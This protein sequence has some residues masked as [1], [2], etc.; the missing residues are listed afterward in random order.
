MSQTMLLTKR[1]STFLANNASPQLHTLLLL[2]P[3]GKILSSSS[4]S[5]ASVLRTQATLACS[6]WNIY[7]P[8]PSTTS[9]IISSSLPNSTPSPDSDKDLNSITIQLSHGIMVIRVLQSGLL[10]VAIGPSTTG[11][12][13]SPVPNS[14]TLHSHHHIASPHTSPSSSPAAHIDGHGSQ[15]S[16]HVD[17]LGVWSFASA[18]S[19][20]PSEAGSVGTGASLGTPASILGVRRQAEEVGRWLEG[21]LEGFVLSAGDGR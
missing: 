9:S 5:S 20:A 3:T 10:F 17:G 6:L 8:F 16:L 18:G 11:V 14:Q 4:P 19:A 7:H 2:S 15:A 13:P 12:G 21:K 1:L